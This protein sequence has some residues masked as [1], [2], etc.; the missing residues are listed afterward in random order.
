M[1]FRKAVWEDLD[2]IERFYDEVSEY[3]EQ[4]INYCG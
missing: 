4:H 3:L 2:E 1:K